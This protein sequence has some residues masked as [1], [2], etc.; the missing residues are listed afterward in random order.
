MKKFLIIFYLLSVK[1]AFAQMF[2]LTEWENPSITDIGKLP[3]TAHYI[4]LANE[5][6]NN[7]NSSRVFSLNGKWK[8]NYVN[9]PNQK[10]INFYT[11]R[12][13]DANWKDI[14]VPSNWELQG[15]G[16]PIYTN[17]N[18]PFPKNPPYINHD[19][20][21][22]GTYRK[23]F[24]L[25]QT[26]NNKEIIL[27]F[28]SVSGCMYV[29][30]NGKQVGMSKASKTPAEFDVTKLIQPGKN[31]LAVQ[32]FRWHDGSYL[33]DQD[34]WRLS[35][36][37]RDVMLIAKPKT[38]IYNFNIQANLINNYTNGELLV[39]TN[40]TNK[41]NTLLNVNLKV[42][43][44]ENQVIYNKTNTVQ[45]N[46][47]VFNTIINNVLPWSAEKPNLYKV[48]ITLINNNKIQE[49]IK[50]NIGFRNVE[51]KNGSLLVNGKRILVKG[52]NRHEHDEVV[53][54][55]PTEEMMLKDIILMKQH[56]INTVRTSHY[57]N[58]TRWYE[59]CNE[60]G[61]YVINEANIESHG[62]GAA[63]QG[64]F[65]TS[66]H[67]AYNPLWRK[68]HLDRIERMYERDKNFT[69]VIIWSLG[70]ECGNGNVFKE[71]YGWLKKTD[72]TR[73]I[74]F[75]QAGEE[76]NT[77]IVAPMYPSIH[78][79]RSY[80]N[81]SNKKR[82]Y[83]MCEYS[84]A[85][86]NSNG[87]FSTYWQI[88]RHGKNMQGGCIWD[89][90][91]QGILTKDENGRKYWAY[92][93]D[94]GSHYLYNDEN[95]CANGLVAA[96]RTPHPALNEVKK[97]YQNI[98]FTLADT[99]QLIINIYNEH[100]FTDLNEFEFVAQINEEGIT[101]YQKNFTIKLPPGKATS[102][103]L[104]FS[105]LSIIKGKE[106]TLQIF[107]Y[108]TVANNTL[109]K[110]YNVAAEQFVLQPT[111]YNA[112]NIN[113]LNTPLKI[114]S[115][116]NSIIFESGYIKGSFNV[117]TG[118]FNSYTYNNK[119]V[120][121]KLPQPYFWRAPTDNDFGNNMPIN[122]G[123]WRTAHHNK[124]T[125]QVKILHQSTDSLV[126]SVHYILTDIAANYTITYKVVPGGI[127]FITSTIDFT[128]TQLPEIP[129]FG[130][131]M[132]LPKSFSTL[133]F[134][135][136]GPFENYSDRN[137]A[138]FLGIY[139]STVENQYT[140]YIRPQENGYKTDTR[141]LQIFGDNN[142]SIKIFA[143][144]QPFCFSALHNTT[145][146]FDPGLTKKQQHV[147][148]II[149]R[150]FTMLHVDYLQRGVGGDNSWGALPH[151]EYR[152]VEKKYTYT[153]AIQLTEY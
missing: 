19:Y 91:D 150:N 95:F 114:T 143:I 36:I 153:Y 18:Y 15:F 71:A 98:Q 120:I 42:V 9:K 2:N 37:E 30:L 138:A 65:D 83:I 87:N 1:Y 46:K 97:I 133:K 17:V 31:I 35:G 99:N 32:V 81:D 60:Y 25:P 47:A 142:L 8:F 72:T 147:S 53:G 93:G 111:T 135:G 145:E 122:L 54:H 51:I 82:P 85:M 45:S 139:Q 21:P 140:P 68:A 10:P 127:V 124:K 128:N 113:V 50:Q 48:V 62:M 116:N 59:L 105:N 6:E 33:E 55:V 136:R 52:V 102:H 90:V 70:N 44:K 144:N 84:H 125:Q 79:M 74:M 109:P 7:R 4:P 38:Y 56:N 67:V 110:G 14:Q 23:E 141:W 126:I 115:N 57:P 123:V 69:S 89:W 66:K 11:A 13:K 76:E 41:Q 118:N 26:F 119:W 149:P 3:Q 112:D 43:N 28:S 104:S 107:A 101:K 92:G 77:D 16:I 80:A 61:L 130:M 64:P 29:W 134:Y 20:N 88:I 24:V 148:D 117:Q 34:F 151:K 5:S 146:D 27:H 94:L 103:Q 86:G 22:V 137:N 73:P 75:E 108:T 132:E 40:I 96:N 49:V 39:Q 131:R 78:Y 63:W 58:D 12:F 106:Y 129:R 152:L 100:N 121:N